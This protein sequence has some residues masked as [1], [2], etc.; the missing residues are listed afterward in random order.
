MYTVMFIHSDK[1]VYCQQCGSRKFIVI[2]CL[3]TD[4]CKIYIFWLPGN[5]KAFVSLS[6]SILGL[7]LKFM[8]NI[9][10]IITEKGT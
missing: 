9:K 1:Y 8:Q 6:T 7:V 4:H 10:E 2:N 5:S 3:L